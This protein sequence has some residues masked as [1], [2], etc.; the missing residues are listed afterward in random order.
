M[1]VLFLATQGLMM[2][3]ALFGWVEL[4]AFF[5]EIAGFTFAIVLGLN[6]YLVSSYLKLTGQPYKYQK[7]YEAVVWIGVTAGVWTL[8]FMIKFFI[9]I[10]G[11]S[12]YQASEQSDNR[13]MVYQACIVALC[14]YCSVVVPIFLVTDSYFIEVFSAAHLAPKIEDNEDIRVTQMMLDNSEYSADIQEGGKETQESA[15]L[16]KASLTMG[17]S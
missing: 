15:Q 5:Y 14:D 8:G 3:L 12:L 13:V 2:F 1:I 6:M 7:S 9:V 10:A 16:P 11:N 17:E 4:N